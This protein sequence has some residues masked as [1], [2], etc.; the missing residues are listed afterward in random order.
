MIGKS[1]INGYALVVEDESVDLDVDIPAH[2]VEKGVPISDHVERQPKKLSI[3]AKLI[4]PTTSHLEAVVEEFYKWEI[5]GKLINYEGRRIYKN[6][7]MSGLKIVAKGDFMNGYTISFTLTEAEISQSSYVA[8]QIAK[9]TKA[10][11]TSGQVQTKNKKSS[12]A[13][14]TVKKGDTYW[15][16]SKKY[17]TSIKQLQNWN[18][19]APE[20]IPIG[21]KLRVV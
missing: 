21:A 15:S 2:P 16:L 8:P 12:P 18:K 5:Q 3:K 1:F 6:M 10:V 4:R 7:L 17:G 11:T 14:H 9:Q 19:Y 20:K 13:Y